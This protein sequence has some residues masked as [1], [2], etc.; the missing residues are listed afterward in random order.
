MA[1]AVN[2]DLVTRKPGMGGDNAVVVVLLDGRS[3]RLQRAY[4]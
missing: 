2:L 3:A 4:H 1:I